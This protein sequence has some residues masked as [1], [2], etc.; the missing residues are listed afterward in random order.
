[1]LFTVFENK[2]P[3]GLFSTTEH[4]NFTYLEKY[5]MQKIIKMTHNVVV[6]KW[7]VCIHICMHV[8]TYARM[9]VCTYVRMHVCMDRL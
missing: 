2:I 8:C 7:C 3:T 6:G 9:Y 1:M 5:K 4:Q